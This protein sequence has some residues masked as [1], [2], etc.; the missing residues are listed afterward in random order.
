MKY[1]ITFTLSLLLYF[2]GYSQAA[3]LDIANNTS[4]D[5]IVRIHSAIA[6]NCVQ[7]SYPVYC[8]PAF[9][10][11]SIPPNGPPMADWTFATFRNV[12]TPCNAAAPCVQFGVPANVSFNNCNGWTPSDVA[13]GSCGA[14]VGI[15]SNVV[16]M[17][18]NYI[19]IQP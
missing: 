7:Y 10:M 15:A 9:T 4:C 1:I 2:G 14:C 12:P 11:I 19:E 8:I 16:W 5:F 18:P 17:S 3:P 13:D 6:P